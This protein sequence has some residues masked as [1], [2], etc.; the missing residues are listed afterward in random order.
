MSKSEISALNNKIMEALKASARK[1]F[2]DKVKNN[3]MI[4][5]SRDGKVIVIKASEL[6]L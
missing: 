3:K 2:E 6:P 4:A 5:V 1:V